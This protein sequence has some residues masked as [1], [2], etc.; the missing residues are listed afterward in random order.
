M[1]YNRNIMRTYLLVGLL[2]LV[3]LSLPSMSKAVEID[4]DADGL[5]DADEINVYYTDPNKADTDGDSYLDG[6]EITHGYSP[7]AGKNKKIFEA[8]TDNDKLVDGLEIAFK[9]NLTVADTDVDGVNDY[10]EVMRATSPTVFGT[11]TAKLERRLEADLTVQRMKYIVDG[12]LVRTFLMS[13]GNPS[14][15]TPVGEYEI[16]Q[17]VAVMR[18]RG[19]GYDLPNVHWNMQFKRGGYFIHEAYWHKNFGKKTNSHGCLNLNLADSALLYKY[20]DI[21]TKVVVVGKTPSQRVVGT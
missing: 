6:N 14:T 16:F 10:E 3:F 20:L 7:L 9:T 2:G 4:T 15:P 5:T 11:S 8:D 12:K 21:G 13:S 1:E 19:V 18:Y 17:K